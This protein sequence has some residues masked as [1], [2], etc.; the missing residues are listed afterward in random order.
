MPITTNNMQTAAYKELKAMIITLK[1]KPGQ[2]IILND[3]IATLGIG[4][5]PIREALIKLKEQDLIQVIPQSGTYISKIDLKQAEDAMFV[6]KLIEKKI[7]QMAINKNDQQ[8]KNNLL[9]ILAT[10]Q[11]KENQQDKN[12]FFHFDNEFHKLFYTSVNKENIW[13]WM[14]SLNTQLERFRYL[15]LTS[16][17][18]N[19]STIIDQHKKILDAVIK[20]DP[21]LGE[22]EIGNHLNLMVSEKDNLLKKYSDYFKNAK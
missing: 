6:R 7:V 13:N 1:F 21:K 2:K 8:L 11:I 3:I 10:A 9:S 16:E 17:D 4:R 22:K 12:S 14:Q 5:T 20:V 19:W 18:L 15:R